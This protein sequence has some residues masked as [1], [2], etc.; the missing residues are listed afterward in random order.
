MSLSERKIPDFIIVGAP[1]CGTTALDNFLSQHPDIFMT[2]KELHFFGSDLESRFHDLTLGN[3]LRY[4]ESE[5]PYKLYGESSVW[6]LYTKN[7]AREIYE[8]NPQAKIIIM[9]RDPMEMLPS[10]HAQFLYN[11]DETVKSFSKALRKDIRRSEAGEKLTSV[12]YTNRPTF[13]DACRFYEPVKRFL[14]LF[15]GEQVLIL[16]NEDLQN[17]FS[18]TYVKVL[19]FL[20][21]D[22]NFIPQKKRVNARRKIRSTNIHRLSKAT[23]EIYRRLFRIIVPSQSRRHRIMKKVQ[24]MNVVKAKNIKPL[25]P[26][27]RTLIARETRPDIDKLARL[28]S[29]DLSHWS[30]E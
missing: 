23:P 7:A 30:R 8:Y 28:L 18:D 4:F 24:D 2:K 17:N 13:F 27:I 1:K 10:L 9:L 5:K 11:G 20:E 6:Y 25:D 21:V 19:N 3:Y 15:G 22:T 26:S 14:N 16:L 12:N 29:R